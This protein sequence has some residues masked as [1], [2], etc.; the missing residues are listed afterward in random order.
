MTAREA[1]DIMSHFWDKYRDEW[2]PPATASRLINTAQIA[3]VKDHIYNS[4]DPTKKNEYQEPRRGYEQTFFDAIELSNITVE[5][6]NDVI[7][8]PTINAAGR[9]LY[10]AL[11]LAFPVDVI[12]D[13]GGII[14][15]TFPTPIHI[16]DLRVW[17]VAAMKFQTAKWIRNNDFIHINDP[18]YGASREHPK[19]RI[20]NGFFQVYPV[21]V[22]GGQS[23]EISVIRTPI[24]MWYD[25]VNQA[26]QIDPELPDTLMYDVLIRAAAYGGIFIKEPDVVKWLQNE[27]Y[28][29]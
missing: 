14:V 4:A 18:L 19:Y 10:S 22:Y 28:R 27:E 20:R 6:P 8:A 16:P 9:F 1:Y 17:D 2:I 11:Q 12:R 21:S 25:P 23:V 26:D 3:V 13:E 24:H 29:Q 15:Q 7:S 5:Y